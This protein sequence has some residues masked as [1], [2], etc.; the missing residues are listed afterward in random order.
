MFLPCN[1]RNFAEL[2][3]EGRRTWVGH[4]IVIVNRRWLSPVL[5]HAS[6]TLSSFV[7]QVVQPPNHLPRAA[8]DGGAQPRTT[9]TQFHWVLLAHAK[10][11]SFSLV[12]WSTDRIWKKDKSHGNAPGDPVNEKTTQAKARESFLLIRDAAKLEDC[13]FTET[14]NAKTMPKY[15][16]R[17]PETLR[18]STRVDKPV[19]VEFKVTLRLVLSVFFYRDVLILGLEKIPR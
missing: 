18:I 9:L 6:T 7:A 8:C 5:L 12:S 1:F 17:F 14:V 2:I 10:T 16:R 3:K 19:P 13:S 15:T 4:L 11:V